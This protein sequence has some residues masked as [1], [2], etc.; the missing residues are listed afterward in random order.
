MAA[1]LAGEMAEE[2]LRGKTITLKLKV[3]TFELRTRSATLDRYVSSAGGAPLFESGCMICLEIA[4]HRLSAE[5][6]LAIPPHSSQL[7]PLCI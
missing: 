1:H 7:S 3:A 2:E 5:C 6:N 4:Q